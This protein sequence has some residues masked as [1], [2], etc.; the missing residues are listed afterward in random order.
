MESPEWYGL[1]EPMRTSVEDWVHGMVAVINTLGWS[2][3]R[4]E[5]LVP[6]KEL[7]V[8]I[9]NAYEGVGYRRLCPQADEKQLSFLAQGAVRGLAHLFWKI[10][11]RDRPGLGED[12]YFSVFNNPEGYWNVEQTHAIAC[13]DAYDRIVTTL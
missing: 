9:Y 7:V 11:I 3:W 10:D 2:V 12:F 1:V 8:R 6:G 4:V 13:G 5:K